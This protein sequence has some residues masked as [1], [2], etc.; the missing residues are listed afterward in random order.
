MTDDHAQLRQAMIRKAV[1][2]QTATNIEVLAGAGKAAEAGE[3]TK[4]LLAFD[5]SESTRK[6]LEQHLARAENANR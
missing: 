2:E 5:N 4:K 1:I 6:I 3:L